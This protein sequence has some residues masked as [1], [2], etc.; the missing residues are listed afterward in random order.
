VG[1]S[2]R[3]ANQATV[4]GGKISLVGGSQRLMHPWARNN[5]ALPPF[6]QSRAMGVYRIRRHSPRRMADVV[7]WQTR[8]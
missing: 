3:N 2:F 7:Y 6:R 1:R 8:L 4:A 5:A